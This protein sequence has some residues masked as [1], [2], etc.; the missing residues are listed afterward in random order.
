MTREKDKKGDGPR[1]DLSTVEV[2]NE[3]LVKWAERCFSGDE[4]VAKFTIHQL[5][6]GK[7][8]GALVRE[9]VVAHLKAE[10]GVQREALVTLCNELHEEMQDEADNLRQTRHFTI[11]AYNAKKGGSFSQKVIEIEPRKYKLRSLGKG[12]DSDDSDEIDPLGGD[13]FR[14]RMGNVL[15]DIRWHTEQ[16]AQVTSAMLA[17][18]M[19]TLEGKDAQINSLFQSNMEYARLLNDAKNNELD[20]ELIREERKFLLEAKR[21][22]MGLLAG[23]LPDFLRRVTGDANG[24]GG[25]TIGGR[26][27]E[28]LAIEAVLDE[29]AGGLTMEEKSKIFGNWT[30]TGERIAPGILT[31]TQVK[32][33]IGVLNDKVPVTEID[34]MIIDGSPDQLTDKQYMEIMEVL[35]GGIDKLLPLVN[36]LQN[37][38]AIIKKAKEN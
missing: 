24:E 17:M 8:E 22:G 2:L 9:R 12:G 11:Q 34:R 27:A 4:T 26:T 7:V 6:K 10:N 18:L 5:L 14:K 1:E 13:I 25:G 35:G 20:R 15:E 3:P 21:R 23:L 33:I 32:I 36:V 31:E 28:S 38:S 30:D 16:N 19:R 37:R 29:K